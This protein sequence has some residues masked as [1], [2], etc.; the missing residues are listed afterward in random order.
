MTRSLFRALLTLSC[1]SL[2]R[3]ALAAPAFAAPGVGQ[4]GLAVGS[5][6]SGVLRAVPC[7]AEPC[8]LEGG[9]VLDVPP[10]FRANISRA[11]LAVVGIGSGRRAIVVTVPGGSSGQSFEAVVAMPVGSRDVRL[12]FQGVTGLVEGS[13]GVRQ[14][15]SVSISE[16]DENGARRIVVGDEREDL[17]LCGRR[18]VLSPSLVSADDLTLR[19]ARVQR[20]SIADRE[21]AAKIEA[22][23]LGPSEPASGAGTLR[24]LGASSALGSPSALSD[25][26][27]GTAWA[28]NRGGSGRG[29]F[30]V[31]SAP[32]ELPIVGFDL[33]V[34]PPGAKPRDV[35][36]ELWLVTR[37]EVFLVALPAEAINSPGQHYRARLPKPVQTDCV[38]LAIESSFEESPDSR[39]AI[40]ELSAVSEFE[41]QAAEA[42]VAALAGGSERAR[43]AGARLR[44]L[45][46]PGYAALTKGFDSLDRAGRSVALGV[47]DSAPCELSAQVYVRALG[48]GVEAQVLHARDRIQRCAA[49]ATAPLLAAASKAQGEALS[50]Y[51]SAL[52]AVAPGQAVTTLTPRLPR[53]SAKDRRSTRV[54]IARAAASPEAAESVRRLLAD[55]SL[56]AP[57]TIELLRALGPRL[58]TF[59]ADAQVAFARAATDA[60]F[61]G[62]YLLLE[63]AAAL[64]TKDANA[65]KI[66]AGGLRG[67]K[68]P[69]I[70]VRS[71][72][73]A[74]REPAY[75]PAFVAALDDPHVRVR[76]AAAHA[77]GEGR[78]VNGSGALG[79]ILEDDSWPIVRR[80]A[81]VGL[82]S[83]PDDPRSRATLLAALEDPAPWVRAAAAES[84]G[85]RRSPGAADPL[86]DLLDDREQPVEVRRAV[87]LSLGAL[88]DAKS[89]DLLDKLARRLADP[90]SS[91]EDRAIGEA[92][93][94]ALVRIHPADLEQRLAPLAKGNTARAVARAKARVGSGCTAR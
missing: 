24:A 90:L 77:L 35:P 75:A 1:W 67:G 20:L 9:L 78:F 81:A 64:A 54:L 27:P 6:A 43:A 30:N 29:E 4:S 28:E 18:A 69:W 87:A 34:A 68:E 42:L 47:I 19:P 36:K 40:A 73:V 14:G 21:G 46:T 38:A 86:R 62:R 83:L 72:E 2:T 80:A 31:L 89:L 44:A 13:D 63:P 45:G 12:L 49:A 3:T 85:L 91:V 48:S 71:I 60:S 82:G 65:A 8:R 51:A 56:P 25:G 55:G 92:S 10:P 15:K 70:R 58:G 59:G 26:N 74:P 7:A 52:S 88:C 17:N 84:L 16:P 66:L 33:L 76:E 5:D 94:Y 22:T 57:A 79:R 61:R 37:K 39:V 23:R 32:P 53:L 93:L 41:G 50:A 11:R